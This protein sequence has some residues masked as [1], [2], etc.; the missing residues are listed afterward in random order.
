MQYQ[1][2]DERGNELEGD[3][4]AQITKNWRRL[5]EVKVGDRFAAYLPRNKFYAVGT[6]I[7]PQS[8]RTRSPSQKRP[9]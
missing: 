7:K 8:K 3:R 1:C 2:A 6:V 4:P 9:G 5:E